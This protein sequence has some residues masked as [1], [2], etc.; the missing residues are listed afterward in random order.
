MVKMLLNIVLIA[1]GLAICF[2]G[3]YLKKVVTCLTGLSWGAVLGAGIAALLGLSGNAS[4]ESAIAIAVI[5]AVIIAVLAIKF[6]RF[7]TCLNSFFSVLSIVFV[8]VLLASG[9]ELGASIGTAIVFG[10]VAFGI[11]IKFYDYSFI[12][13][14]AL[15]GGFI[16][17]LGFSAAI[18]K[19]S[20][21]NF[22]GRALWSG[23]GSIGQIVTQVI[24]ITLIL[25]VVGSVFQFKRNQ[26]TQEK[27]QGN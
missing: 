9:G 8:I 11:S 25:T 7:C 16:A 20:L 23:V 3:I 24:V 27:K 6:D 19:D 10:L 15:T 13:S 22:V 12:I 5:I 1:V 21:S 18:N 26:K 17:S 14:T 4:T 2:G